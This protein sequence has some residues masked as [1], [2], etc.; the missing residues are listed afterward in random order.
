M[1]TNTQPRISRFYLIAMALYLSFLATIV[2]FADR[3]MCAWV[4]TMSTWVP[5]GD[6]LCHLILAGLLSFFL[7]S[8]L[9]CRKVPLRGIPIPIGTMIACTLTIGEEIS[10][11]WQPARHFQFLDLSGDII[12][13]FVFGRL[14]AWNLHQRL[15]M[16]PTGE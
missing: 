11:I 16:R 12:G 8:A 7:N 5:H 9:Q 10:Q 14:A 6:S 4:F 13:I 15:R 1:I 2:T 3:S